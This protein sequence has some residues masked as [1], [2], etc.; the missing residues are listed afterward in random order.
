MKRA[1]KSRPLSG[2][3]VLVTRAEAQAAGLVLRLR[4]L[5]AR[6]TAI[7]TIDIRPPKSYAP[8]DRAL[9]GFERYDWLIVTS[10]NGVTALRERLHHVAIPPHVLRHLCVAAIGPATRQSV[11]ELGW[12]VSVMPREYV[13]EAVVAALRKKVR[14]ERV[15]LV[16][17]QVARDVI[18]RELRRAG[19]R[20]DVVAAYQTIAPPGSR[21]KLRALLRSADRPTVIT[22]TSSSTARNFAALVGKDVLYS[23]QLD[24]V[25]LASIGPVTSRTLRKLRLEPDI[26]ARDYTVEGLLTAMQAN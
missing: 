13:A 24:G 25:R 5:G 26:E 23:G 7:P 9:H 22:F 12:R 6:V 1:R 3:H 15:L 19:A 4:S 21:A 11:E 10:V 18:P 17:A 14:G 16:R 2:E 20:V 8:L